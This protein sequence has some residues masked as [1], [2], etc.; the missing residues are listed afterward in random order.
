MVC[1]FVRLFRYVAWHVT[2]MGENNALTGFQ[3]ELGICALIE[4]SEDWK[5]LSTL[6]KLMQC[7]LVLCRQVISD[8]SDAQKHYLEGV[9]KLDSEEAWTSFVQQLI[10]DEKTTPNFE[11]LLE[12]V[13]AAVQDSDEEPPQKL[14]KVH[15]E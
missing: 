2:Q 1:N 7:A 6:Q 4:D 10:T 3:V 5:D 8:A 14:A 13:T 11:V 12:K 9:S 15:D